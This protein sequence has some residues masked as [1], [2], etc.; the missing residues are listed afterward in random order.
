MLAIVKAD[1]G[2]MEVWK[3]PQASPVSINLA[4]AVVHVLIGP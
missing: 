3:P 4:R 2:E 1:L